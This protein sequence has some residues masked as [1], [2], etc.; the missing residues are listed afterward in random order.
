MKK[1]IPFLVMLFLILGACSNHDANS[2]AEQDLE[3]DSAVAESSEMEF[4]ESAEDRADSGTAAGDET[5]TANEET[6]DTEEGDAN[7]KVIYTANLD[8]ETES[9]AELNDHIQSETARLGGYVVEANMYRDMDNDHTEGEIVVRIPQ[10]N[11]DDF[12]ELIE[13]GSSKVL[14]HHVSGQDVTEEF[15]DL[16]S[17]LKSKKAVEERL[18]EFMANAK[19]TEDLLAISDNLASVQEEIETITGRMNYLQDKTDLATVTINIRENNVT[20]SGMNDDDLNTWE[21]MKKQFMRSIN[22]IITA[23]SAMVIFIG[24]NAPV[25]ALLGMIGLLIF[26]IIRRN[27]RKNKIPE[28]EQTDK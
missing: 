27:R 24:G 13:T 22:F 17:R 8:V 5:E 23:I 16:E 21:E 1:V 11:F 10:E 3:Q 15:I 19:K 6:E 28:Q 7:R 9:Y 12:I 25:I 18:L 14:D 20:L 2:T 4:T 26:L